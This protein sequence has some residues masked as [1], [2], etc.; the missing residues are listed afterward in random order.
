MFSFAFDVEIFQNFSS[1]IFKNIITK[2]YYEF[3]MYEDRDDTEKLRQFMQLAEPTLVGFNSQRF[4]I[5]ILA[6]WLEG[7][8]VSQLHD[9]AHT[10]ITTKE[11]QNDTSAL[12]THLMKY[13]WESPFKGIDLMKV[14]SL[15][16]IGVSLKQLAIM[17]NWPL[18][19]DL[20]F[21]PDYHVKPQDVPLIL[22]YN[23]NDVDIT[24]D[25][26]LGSSGEIKVREEVADKYGIDA[27]N[28]SQS[29]MANALITDIYAQSTGED[30]YTFR[31]LRTYRS[32]V[33]ICDCIGRNIEFQSPEFK[34][35][36]DKLS[37]ITITIDNEDDQNMVDFVNSMFDDNPPVSKLKE[38]V[39]FRDTTYEIGVGGLHSKDEGDIFKSNGDGQIVD[40]DVSSFYPFI[41]LLNE[42]K[43]AHLSNHFVKVLRTITHDRI[44]AKQSGDS[45]KAYALKIVINSIFGKLGCSTYWLYDPLAFYSVTISGQLYLLMLIEQLEGAGFPILSANTDGVVARVKPG[46]YDDY[47]A[48]CKTW[49]DQTGFLLDFET[50]ERYIRRDVNSYIALSTSGKVKTK[51]AFED[52]FI[53][54]QNDFTRVASKR[55]NMP[56][57]ASALRAHYLEGQDIRSFVNNTNDIRLFLTTQKPG[58]KFRVLYGRKE[59]Q[60][61]NRYYFATTGDILVK[62]DRSKR[63][64][65]MV[66]RPVQLLND[67][68]SI[69]AAD[70]PYLDRDAYI[71]EIFKITD[72]ISPRAKKSAMF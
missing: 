53:K 23:R 43:P 57:I 54:S 66:A 63:K 4:D 39:C 42:I 22:S 61:T 29:H 67:M 28:L 37:K 46:A 20:P 72:K 2:R 27:L 21:A 26:Y 71:R 35:F 34:A 47:I 44:G 65:S 60:R 70:Y 7:H 14:L 52:M 32:T 18:I 55:Y 30:P 38:S 8:N 19:L 48:V 45:T 62:Q 3:V 10:I 9:A 40:A 69:D 17:R 6:Y 24:E 5:P 31:D 15:D 51:G 33:N 1:V 13:V 50:Y 41:M 68:Q 16:G 58:R 59:V 64:I 25:V 36:L 56:I 11:Y 49:Q 12:Y